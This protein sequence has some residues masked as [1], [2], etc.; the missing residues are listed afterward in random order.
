MTLPT[1]H[2]PTLRTAFAALILA[3]SAAPAPAADVANGEALAKRWCAACHLVSADQKRAT[4]D[5]PSFRS[6]GRRDD[7]P[8]L[9]TFLQLSHPRMPDMAL[10]RKEI[11]D[12]T[13]YMRT[14]AP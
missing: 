3:M 14:K 7:A 1:T 8:A 5:A 10:S 9:E 2:V 6:I 4:P 13:A 12:L 11:A